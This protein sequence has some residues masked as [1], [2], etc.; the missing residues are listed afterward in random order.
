[1]KII[2]AIFSQNNSLFIATDVPSNCSK[3]I[4][5]IS[6]LSPDIK[7]L[8][9]YPKNEDSA[10]VELSVAAMANYFIGNDQSK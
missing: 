4:E 1:M 9:F 7:I 5:F 6:H 3:I 2:E 10:N 8:P